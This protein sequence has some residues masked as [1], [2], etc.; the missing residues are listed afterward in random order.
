[1]KHS[2]ALKSSKT[3]HGWV[4]YCEYVSC[5]SH[6]LECPCLSE[7]IPEPLPTLMLLLGP[8]TPRDLQLFYVTWPPPLLMNGFGPTQGQ[9]CHL[10]QEH[11]RITKR[12]NWV[13]A[14]L[15]TER[16][17]TGN[18][19]TATFC[20]SCQL[21]SRKKKSVCRKSGNAADT[22]RSRGGVEGGIWT[23]PGGSCFPPVGC[24]PSLRSGHIPT[25]Q[26][27]RYPAV[28]F[29]VKPANNFFLMITIK[30]SN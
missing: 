23:H 18:D 14:S 11:E 1:M 22:G 6:P 26:G 19:G 2:P 28:L 10:S 7:G 5:S 9:A 29:A 25:L 30:S 13:W 20:L 21:R 27:L 8:P 24:R 12:S 15:L 4:N 3:R 17:K 16:L